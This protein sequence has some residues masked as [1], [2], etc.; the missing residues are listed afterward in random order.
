MLL[1]CLQLV[2]ALL[3]SQ[4]VFRWLTKISLSDLRGPPSKSWLA[5]AP[6]CVLAIV[7]MANIRGCP[8]NVID[9]F[10]DNTGMLCAQWLSEY[11][12][13][14]K[15]H[16]QVGTSDA[17]LVS[18]PAALRYIFQSDRAEKFVRAPEWYAVGDFLVG[19]SVGTVE[20][21]EHKRHRKVSLPFCSCF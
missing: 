4:R 1:L 16:P 2:A 6:R 12:T 13:V 9:L 20:G 3:V 17:I 7:I 5:G 18:D 11:G 14:M 19:Q 15:L 10:E 8:G 21:D